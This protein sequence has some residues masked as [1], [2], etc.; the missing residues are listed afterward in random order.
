MISDCRPSRLRSRQ[1]R[2]SSGVMPTSCAQMDRRG[3]IAHAQDGERV[4]GQRDRRGARFLERPR[5]GEELVHRQRLR[6]IEFHDG[7]R[8]GLQPVEDRRLLR[9]SLRR[10][11]DA[12]LADR[13]RARATRPAF[14]TRTGF[15]L[16]HD[17]RP[18]PRCAR[19]ACRNRRR[20]AA[21]LPRPSAAAWRQNTRRWPR[22]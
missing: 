12:G 7:N 2:C 13:D 21:R 18:W 8:L 16:A 11:R 15:R 17:L 22:S 4:V 10:V 20:S 6:R 14:F 1:A 9:V 5:A 3:E 19:A